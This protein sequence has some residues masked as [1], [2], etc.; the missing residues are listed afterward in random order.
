MRGQI[1]PKM[2]RPVSCILPF[3]DERSR[4]VQRVQRKSR[5]SG[6]ARLLFVRQDTSERG[7]KGRCWPAVCRYAVLLLFLLHGVAG[8]TAENAVDV[9]DVIAEALQ[10]G[11]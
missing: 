4:S 5:T 1:A 8:A 3:R 2:S 7:E 10:L 9:A 11:L 6:E